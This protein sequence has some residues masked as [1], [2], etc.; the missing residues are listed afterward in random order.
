MIQF[1]SMMNGQKWVKIKDHQKKAKESQE[2]QSGF[3]VMILNF[4]ATYKGKF[5]AQATY[6]QVD[7]G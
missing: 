4:A 6:V 7:S 3:F 2:M 1:H 5:C